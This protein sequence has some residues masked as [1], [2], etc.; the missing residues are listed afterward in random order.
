MGRT[1]GDL[2]VIR[3]IIYYK[4]SPHEQKPFATAFAHGIPNFIPRTLATMPTWLPVFIM[5]YI[6]YI[7]IEET[8]RRSQRKNPR[9]FM[10]ET[11][12]EEQPLCRPR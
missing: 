5:G 10:F 3:G 9:D 11:P 6:T 7:S 8:Y 1:F 12:P 4:I 2:A